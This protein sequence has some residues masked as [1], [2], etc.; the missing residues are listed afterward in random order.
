MLKQ[1]YSV[2]LLTL[3]VTSHAEM[4]RM[5]SQEAHNAMQN[6]S[7]VLIDVRETYEHAQERIDNSLNWPL[8]SLSAD[9]VAK[10]QAFSDEGKEIILYC[11]SG[12]RSVVAATQL[13]QWGFEKTIA[14][15]KGGI[16]AWKAQGLPVVP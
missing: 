10:L 9:H 13:K 15:I 4:T 7:A 11:R 16:I 12:R 8:S 2:L 5:S 14:D 6:Q 3:G 1:L